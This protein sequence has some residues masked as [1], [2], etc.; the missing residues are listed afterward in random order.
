MLIR[1]A[2]FL[3]HPTHTYVTFY[4]SLIWKFSCCLIRKDLRYRDQCLVSS[5]LLPPI[6]MRICWYTV[7]TVKRVL[8]ISISLLERKEVGTFPKI[9]DS[10]KVGARRCID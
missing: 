8:L 2:S 5:S 9:S 1:S 3:P 10:I 4:S 6:L 7:F